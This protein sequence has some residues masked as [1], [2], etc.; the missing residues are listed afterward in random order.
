M[1]RNEV[2]ARVTLALVGAPALA[3]VIA[4]VPGITG[5]T[6]F[7]VALRLA[8]FGT[9]MLVLLP[10]SGSPT[11]FGVH[12]TAFGAGTLFTASALIAVSPPGAREVAAVLFVAAVEE[13]V[14]RRGLPDAA[15]VALQR[16]RYPARPLAI[17]LS[18]VAFA[19][20]HLAVDGS[21]SQ[22]LTFARLFAAGVCLAV[23]YEFCGLVAA[24]CLHFAVNELMR[25]GLLG[26]FGSANASTIWSAAALS[27]IGVSLIGS[28]SRVRPSD[29][30]PPR[31]VHF[32]DEITIK[33]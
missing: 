14:F 33:A 10:R 23:V 5:A 22:S 12:G 6:P 15:T 18:Q 30:G 11:V 1:K 25:N 28:M 21:L 19:I 27:L 13:W 4:L 2:I 8:A 16:S 3:F 29:E 9:C 7:H 31:A 26:S 20:S 24:I 17:A 32:D